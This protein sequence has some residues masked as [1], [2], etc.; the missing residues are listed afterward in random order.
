MTVGHAMSFAKLRER[1]RGRV[2]VHACVH[3]HGGNR[4][5]TKNTKNG[6]RTGQNEERREKETREFISCSKERGE[7][8]RKQ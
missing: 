2:H 6:E 1:V 8:E 4:D 7:R 5:W 3:V